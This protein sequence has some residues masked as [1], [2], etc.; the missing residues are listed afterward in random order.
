MDYALLL[1]GVIHVAGLAATW[2]TRLSHGLEWETASQRVY[3]VYLAACGL[4]VCW[5]HTISPLACLFSGFS[6]SM[7]VVCGVWDVGPRRELSYG[8]ESWD[9][10]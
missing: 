3:M 5:A 10:A 2:W 8:S 6:L 4:S 7:M 9:A 1:L